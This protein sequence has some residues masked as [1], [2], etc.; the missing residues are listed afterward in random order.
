MDWKNKGMYSEEEIVQKLFLWSVCQFRTGFESRL[1]IYITRR[2][3]ARNP[4]CAWEK[5]RLNQN[6][7]VNLKA[8]VSRE[9]KR[10]LC[11]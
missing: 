7:L 5:S 11:N 2:R 6:I 1:R 10:L 9:S 4:S 3:A 8:Y